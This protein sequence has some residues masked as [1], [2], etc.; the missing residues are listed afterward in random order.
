VRLSC[1]QTVWVDLFLVVERFFEGDRNAR[2]RS[3]PSPGRFD[4][5]WRK[6]RQACGLAGDRLVATGGAWIFYFADAPTLVREL[7]DL[8]RAAFGAYVMV[9]ILTFTTYTSSAADARAGLQ[10]YVPLA[11]HPGGD[12]GR[13]FAGR[14]LQ[15]LAR[16]TAHA[17]CQEGNRSAGEASATASTAMPAL[18]SVQWASTSATAS[19]WNAS[20]A[21]SASMPAIL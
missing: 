1:P 18:P 14:H 3:T 15:R 5:L 16:R 2:M 9:A 17:P 13:Q 7:R 6:T 11:A 21:R 20:P 10:V 8:H 4:K 19:S 12:A